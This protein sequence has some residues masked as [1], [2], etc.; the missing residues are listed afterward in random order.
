MELESVDCIN[1]NISE[2][3][4]DSPV[5]VGSKYLI[6]PK[7]DLIIS[8]NLLKCSDI[9]ISENRCY[10]VFELDNKKDYDLYNFFV[11]M[12]EKNICEIF[13]NSFEWFRK[14]MPFDV[15]ED[16]LKPFVRLSKDKIIIKVLIPYKNKEIKLEN[17]ETII[18]NCKIAPY[19]KYRG[20]SIDSQQFSSSWE[21]VN[22]TTDIEFNQ[23]YE[24][25]NKIDEENLVSYI[26]ENDLENKQKTDIKETDIKENDI[27]ETDIKE[28]DIKE[29]DIKETDIKETDIKEVKKK[30]KK[31][32]K[33]VRRVFRTNRGIKILG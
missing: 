20:I 8:A 7:H 31:K 12:D 30:V 32:V 9:K 28:T 29:T 27:K 24:I 3:L 18:N 22:F 26:Q 10:V 5:K 21:L 4:Y 11:D 25:F 6:K 13:K 15:V 33:K 23:Q 16:Y 2:V 1:V 14:T 17:Y 19:F